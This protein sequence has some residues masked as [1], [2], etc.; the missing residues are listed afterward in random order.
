MT[1]T[2]LVELEAYFGIRL[3]QEYW[4]VMQAY[5]FDGEHIGTEMLIDDFEVLRQTNQ[6]LARMPAT[7]DPTAGYFRIGSDGSELTF[8]IRPTRESSGVWYFD[9]ESGEFQKYC[10]TLLDYV[11]KCRRIDLGKERLPNEESSIPEWAKYVYTLL[12]I[13]AFI[14][15][16][17][18]IFH[19]T[20]WLARAL[21]V[22]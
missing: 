20:R 8:F 10:D 15:F 4:D 7:D 16:G 6:E 2:S 17:Y 19:A 3:P 13:G 22:G 11:E 12:I 14:L 1:S 5:P 21:G 9:I 18:A